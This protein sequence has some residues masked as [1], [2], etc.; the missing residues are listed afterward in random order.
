M[1]AG[2][3]YDTV[4]TL[5]VPLMLPVAGQVAHTLRESRL[6]EDSLCHGESSLAAGPSP[7]PWNL[8]KDRPNQWIPR[9][10]SCAARSAHQE[11]FIDN[12]AP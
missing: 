5:P 11:I 7:S 9:R 6:S 12:D 2:G 10:N 1:V 3:C 4:C 8:S